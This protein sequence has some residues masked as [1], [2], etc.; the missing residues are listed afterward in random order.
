MS[1][2]AMDGILLHENSYDKS[3][4]Q[5]FMLSDHKACCKFL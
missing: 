4:R 5:N 1:V 3:G 2:V